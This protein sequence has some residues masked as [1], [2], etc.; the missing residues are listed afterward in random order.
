MEVSRSFRI[1]YVWKVMEWK[2]L[3]SSGKFWKVLEGSGK[4]R[5]LED[6]EVYGGSKIL[7]DLESS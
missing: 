1:Y 3:E 4:C 6:V 7:E 5:T 2:A